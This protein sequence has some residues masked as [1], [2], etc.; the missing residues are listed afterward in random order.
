ML[1][2]GIFF[3]LLDLPEGEERNE[4]KEHLVPAHEPPF[5]T[6]SG[7]YGGPG[8]WG[9]LH[10]Y[11]LFLHSSERNDIGTTNHFLECNIDVNHFI[12][13]IIMAEIVMCMHM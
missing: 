5:Y 13:K 11:D 8:T 9:P 10:N 4:C 3:L 1:N 12:Y 2:P 7:C 6:H